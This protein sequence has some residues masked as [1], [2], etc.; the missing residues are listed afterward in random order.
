MAHDQAAT[1]D[2]VDDRA[3]L[4]SLDIPVTIEK[5]DNDKALMYHLLSSNG[6]KAITVGYL[7][8]Q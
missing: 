3:H 6:S 7:K 1:D 2:R 4:E 8:E 5:I